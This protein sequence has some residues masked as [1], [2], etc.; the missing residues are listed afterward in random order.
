MGRRAHST[1]YLAAL[2]VGLAGWFTAAQ[3][4][5]TFTWSPTAGTGVLET[6]ANWISTPPNTAPVTADN[7][8]LVFGASTQ[9]HVSFGSSI[10]VYSL[11]F[12]GDYP[13]YYLEG[14]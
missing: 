5:T 3:A 1:A 14:N 8:A 11:E 9:S 10:D 13:H 7:A 6:G 2:C 4:Q 12:S